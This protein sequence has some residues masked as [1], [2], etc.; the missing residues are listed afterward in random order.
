MTAGGRHRNVAVV[1][2]TVRGRNGDL[3]VVVAAKRELSAAEPELLVMGGSSRL[4]RFHI[5][6][7]LVRSVSAKARSIETDLDVVDFAAR[8]GDDGVVDLHVARMP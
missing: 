3:G 2:F 4:L 8:A 6:E 5:P 1:G 7:S